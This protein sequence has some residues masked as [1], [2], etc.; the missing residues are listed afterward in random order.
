M[1]CFVLVDIGGTAIKHAL[2]DAEGTIYARGQRPTEAQQ[3]G[4]SI[5]R[6]VVE[7]VRQYRQQAGAGGDRDVEGE[8]DARGGEV[9]G[10]GGDGEGDDM[11]FTGEE[12]G[13]KRIKYVIDNLP[14]YVIA[15]RVQYYGP[16]GKL[17]TESLKD[18]TRRAVRK[19]YASL[20]DF[21]RQIGRA[22]V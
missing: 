3:G 20:D 14:I 15:E 12:D 22:H 13:K 2:S 9:D 16:D 19:E 8:R 11:D 10:S 17:I 6:K 18:Y 5:C 4:Q 21:L 1:S 7:I